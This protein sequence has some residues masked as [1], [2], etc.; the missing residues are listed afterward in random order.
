LL[1][2]RNKVFALG[3]EATVALAVRNK[4]YGFLTVRYFWEAYA[5]T[6]TQGNA[7]IVQATLLTR[8]VK[9]PGT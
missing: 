4:V 1:R 9:V 3:P 5:R 2:G 7:F 8:P 6:T